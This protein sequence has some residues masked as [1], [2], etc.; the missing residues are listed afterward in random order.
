[1]QQPRKTLRLRSASAAPEGPA[2]TPGEDIVRV[3]I[4]RRLCVMITYN[5]TQMQLAPHILFTR[6]GDPFVDGVITERGGRPP[7]ELKLGTFK[8]AGLSDIVLTANRFDT[9][10]AFDRADPKYQEAVLLVVE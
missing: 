2:A 10:E 5:R 8:L 4:E 6:H 3:A 9:F 7:R 1:M